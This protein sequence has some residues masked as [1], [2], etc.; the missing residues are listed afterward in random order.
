MKAIGGTP[1]RVRLTIALQTYNRAGD[2]YLKLMLDSI[3]NQTYSEF[4]LFIMDNHSTDETMDVVTAYEDPRITYIRQPAGGSATTNTN[5]AVWMARGDY[6]L[7]T[8]DDDVMEPHMVQEMITYLDEYPETICVASNVSLMGEKG[9]TL[10]ERLYAEYSNRRFEKGEYIKTYLREKFWFPTPTLMYRR[11][12]YVATQPN[13][14]RMNNPAYFPSGDI[15]SI[16]MFN[17]RGPV[18]FLA[19]PLLRYRQHAGQESRNVHQSEPMLQLMSMLKQKKGSH[20][21]IEPLLPE[22]TGTWSKYKLQDLL[23]KQGNS[24]NKS[25]IKKQVFRLYDRCMK[26][27]QGEEAGVS[28]LLPLTIMAQL[29]AKDRI[30]SSPAVSLAMDS[31]SAQAY[32]RWNGQLAIGSS[33]LESHHELHRIAVFGSMLTAYLLIQDAENAGIQVVGIFDSSLARIGNT[34]FDHPIQA[35]NELANLSADCD[36]II[37]TSERDHEEAIVQILA[38]HLRNKNIPITTW[39]NLAL[40][41]DRS[42]TIPKNAQTPNKEVAI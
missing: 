34:I 39:K 40:L 38:S 10:Q 25:S 12:A 3:L 37:I 22:I 9:E 11:D 19:N 7:A 13:N 14:V 27:L 2:G 21:L 41:H 20:P 30:A 23:F 31:K 35:I 24:K 29:L 4:E 16:F 6:V 32:T 36:A 42:L 17:L 15:W 28:E 33:L 26:D 1:Q 5:R 18:A 8:H